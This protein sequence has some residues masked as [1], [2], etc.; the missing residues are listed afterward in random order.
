MD[1][2]VAAEADEPP[3]LDDDMDSPLSSPLSSLPSSPIP[4]PPRALL[5]LPSATSLPTHIPTTGQAASSNS[6]ADDISTTSQA[7]TTNSSTDD[8]S[9]A[10]FRKKKR[11]HKSRTK[12]RQ[13]EAHE[14]GYTPHRESVKRALQKHVT[15]SDPVKSNISIKDTDMASTG[16]VGV[17]EQR[18]KKDYTL[19]ELVGEDSKFRFRLIQWDGT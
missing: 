4:S 18:P 5:P 10:S 8:I 2:A 11:S 1:A 15:P 13:T 6:L 14:M 12:R 7:V 17:R 19:A 9:K 3:I 16:Y